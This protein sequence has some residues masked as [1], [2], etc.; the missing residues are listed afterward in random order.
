MRFLLSLLSTLL[1][2]GLLLGIFVYIASR[3]SFYF[4]TDSYSWLFWII[5][6]LIF[7]IL[8][9]SIRYS[10]SGSVAGHYV[11][12]ISSLLFGFLTYLLFTILLTDLTTLLFT[13]SPVQMGLISTGTASAITLYGLYQSY[14]TRVSHL[15]IPIKGLISPVKAMHLTDIHLGHHRGRRFLQ[16][17][18]DLVRLQKPD[19]IFVTGDL[20]D[21]HYGL[22]EDTLKPLRQLNV[23]WV[24][25]EGNHDR[26]VDVSK[27]KQMVRDIGGIV[28]ENEMLQ[29]KGLQIIGLDHMRADNE[30]RNMHASQS[31]PTIKSVLQDLAP[32]KETPTI[33][34]HHSPDGDIHANDAGVDLYLSGH[35]HGGQMFPAT[36]IARAMFKYNRGLHYF[37]DM[38]IYVCMGAGTFGP[39]LRVG[40]FSEITVINLTPKT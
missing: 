13:F 19:I 31:G 6:I 37:E 4:T 33:L 14:K 39:P 24:F 20:F 1:F 11:H 30:S 35:T 15:S 16:K 38:A 7:G 8:T 3:T 17:L 5:M 25:I 40:T 22:D 2:L 10:M 18:V 21:A 26:Y 32:D 9:G 29:E 28:L 12:V 36:L 34:L 27:I 23:P